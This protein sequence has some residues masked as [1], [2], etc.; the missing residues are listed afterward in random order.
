[1]GKCNRS[2]TFASEKSAFL[3]ETFTHTSDIAEAL[4]S[5]KYVAIVSHRNPDGDALGSSL[6]MKLLLSS[7]GHTVNVIFPSEYPSDFDWMPQV[8]E[9]LIYDQQPEEVHSALKRSEFIMAL[10]FNGIGSD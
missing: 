2:L 10:D 9:S 1:M 7:M 3:E 6:A 5:P 4:R 8:S